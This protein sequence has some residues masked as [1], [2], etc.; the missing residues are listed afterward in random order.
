MDQSHIQ[1]A[2]GGQDTHDAEVGVVALEARLHG[3]EGKNALL[4]K[5]LSGVLEGVVSLRVVQADAV[6]QKVVVDIHVT[7]DMGGCCGTAEERV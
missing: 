1:D 6:S 3:S 2:P 7:E 4:Q 5:P